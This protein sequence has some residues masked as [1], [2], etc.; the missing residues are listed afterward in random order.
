MILLNGHALNGSLQWTERHQSHQ[1]EQSVRV[2][3]GGR[4]VINAAPL[5]NG[6]NITLVASEDTGW[7]T[8]TDVEHLEAMAAIPGAVWS[9]T[10]HGEVV[11]ALVVFR[12][13]E[14]PA[15]DMSP[16]TPK[17]EPLPEDYYI[18]TIKLMQV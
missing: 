16:L 12:H 4:T 14:A 7:L 9:F 5:V 6:R 18:G 13:H 2:T 17:K 8:K 10:Y 3:L 1:V 15:L 11:D